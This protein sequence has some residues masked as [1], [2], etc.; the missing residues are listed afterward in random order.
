M[1]TTFPD[2][3]ESWAL[4]HGLSL[5]VARR[6]GRLA[7][8]VDRMRIL[9]SRH[10]THDWLVQARVTDLP[11]DERQREALVEKA[12]AAAT[13]RMVVSASALVMD[14][15][16]SALWLQTHLPQ[17]AGVAALEACLERMANDIEFW[18]AM[19]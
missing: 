18:R 10:A 15:D 12:A 3:L 11:A 5:D 8:P 6:S 2:W 13:A 7:I 14:P 1:N 19:L 4:A 16:R 17:D 9:L